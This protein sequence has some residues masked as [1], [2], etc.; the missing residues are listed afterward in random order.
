MRVAD[1]CED[2][3]QGHNL[4]MSVPFAELYD[5]LSHVQL[6]WK[7]HARVALEIHTDTP[8]HTHIHRQRTS[9]WLAMS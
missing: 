7:G 8:T 1:V 2:L 9:L 4:S 5:S 6:T 3:T